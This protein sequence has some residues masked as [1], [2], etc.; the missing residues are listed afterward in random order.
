ME[1]NKDKNVVQSVDKRNGFIDQTK[2]ILPVVDGGDIK[3]IFDKIFKKCI[4]LSA[5]SVVRMLN[6]MFG[7]DYPDDSKLTYNWTEFVKDNTM[8][9][10]LADCIVT[11]NGGQ[12]YHMEA[13]AYDDNEIIFRVFQYGFEHAKRTA[14]KEKNSIILNFPEPVIIYLYYENDVPD[15]YVMKINFK[16]S[17]GGYEYVVPVI[18]I[19]EL[20]AEEMVKR[21]MII[22]IPFQLMKLRYWVDKKKKVMTKTPEELKNFIECDIIGSINK[23]LDLGNI[24]DTDASRLKRYSLMLRDYL[25]EHMEADGLEVLK[26]MMDHSFM[27]DVDIICEKYEEAQQKLEE[28]QQKLDES[29]LKLGES[30]QKL[31]ES[32]QKLGELQKNNNS[33]QK[34]NDELLKKVKAYEEQYGIL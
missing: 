16:A 11:V 31:D 17:D 5:K 19:P 22:L 25:C 15:E 23:N 33:L 26:G 6:G 3:Q 13:Q 1:V 20:S 7:T 32:Q 21:N 30:Q 34:D 28:T 4:T 9:T 14:D 12:S 24:T 10:I 8:T 18:K 2:E 27:T 29:Q